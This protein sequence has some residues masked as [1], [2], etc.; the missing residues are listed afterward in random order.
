[1]ARSVDEINITNWQVLPQTTAIT[2]RSFNI[3][4]KWTRDDGT[5]GTH[6]SLRTFPAALSAMPNEVLRRF[7]EQMICAIVRVELGIDTWEQY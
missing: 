1:M 7:V 3:E 5:K 6:S 2:R 4:I